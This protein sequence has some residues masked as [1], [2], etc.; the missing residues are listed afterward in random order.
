[1]AAASHVAAYLITR[2]MKEDDIGLSNLKLQKLL[3]YSQGF[4]LALYGT[5]L[6]EEQIEAWTHGPVCP[7][8]YRE[9]KRYG[10]SP[11]DVAPEVPGDA[12]TEDQAELLEEV[13]SVFGQFSAWKLRDMT[14]EEAPWL[15]YE[16]EGGVIPHE[17]LQRYFKTRIN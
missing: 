8:I 11:I 4:H 13:F 15:E 3:Y 12:L 6:F 10:S 9:Y 1:M 14:H 5:P 2:A 17:A 7:P 16:D